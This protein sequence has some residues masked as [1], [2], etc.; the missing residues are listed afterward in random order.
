M[1]EA[2]VG[3]AHAAR[4]GDGETRLAQREQAEGHGH[5]V[6]SG[7]IETDWAWRPAGLKSQPVRLLDDAQ[8]G[9]DEAGGEHVW[10]IALLQARVGDAADLHLVVGEGGGDGERRQEVGAVGEVEAVRSG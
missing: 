4:V 9:G 5:A 6:V 10:P 1:P 7:G 3:L 8:P 2:R